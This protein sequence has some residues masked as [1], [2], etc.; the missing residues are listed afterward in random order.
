MYDN[1][2]KQRKI[3][4]TQRLSL[5][6]S[7]VAHQAGAYPGFLSMKALGVFLLP[8]QGMLVHPRATPSITFL[9]RIH[10]Y[11]F[12]GTHVGEDRLYES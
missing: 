11:A 5:P 4:F 1:E 9:G 8:L 6:M 3:K 7:L 2:L 10:R 12:A